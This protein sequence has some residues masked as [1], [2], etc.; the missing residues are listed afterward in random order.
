MPWT[1]D[2]VPGSVPDLPLDQRG[3]WVRVAN[4]ALESGYD[5]AAAIAI[6][7]TVV[8]NMQAWGGLEPSIIMDYPLARP[9]VY[10]AAVGGEFEIKPDDVQMLAEAINRL[11]ELGKPVALID[12]HGSGDYCGFI[13][14]ARVEGDALRGALVIRDWYMWTGIS[15]GAFGLSME[16]NVDYTSEA[17]T[18]GETFPYWPTAWAVLPA[19]EQ[20]A[21]PA[22]EPIA[23]AEA[24]RPVRLYA[25][26]QAPAGGNSPT[27]KG[28]EQMD[29]LKEKL[30]QLEAA[31][32]EQADKIAALETERDGLKDQLTAAEQE[33]DQLKAEKQAAEL[34]AEEAAVTEGLNAVMAAAV[35]GVRARMQERIAAAETLETRKALLSAWEPLAD[36]D[37]LAKARLQ[38]KESKP[39]SETKDEADRTL[40]AAEKLAA[41]KGI[42]FV[43]AL[44]M[45]N[46]KEDE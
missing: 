23:A 10:T 14:A 28:D 31:Q 6:A 39:A 15:T 32:Q 35:P 27:G 17:Y 42:S 36:K 41:D 40:E 8:K 20:P 11:Y 2:T 7:W 46:R 44:E 25:A 3:V 1:I 24:P 22:G 12:G 45:V 9:G 34:E 29:E 19:G 4:D 26:E 16:A 18:G 33:R 21:I 30:A 37:E 5:E 43:K 13:P 38:A